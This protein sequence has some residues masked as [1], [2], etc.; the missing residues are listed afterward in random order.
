MQ[1]RHLSVFGQFRKLCDH[2]VSISYQTASIPHSSYFRL[3]I[4]SNHTRKLE[5]VAY[6][7]NAFWAWWKFPFALR[8]ESELPIDGANLVVRPEKGV[9]K[10]ACNECGS[11]YRQMAR[12]GDG[13]QRHD[14]N[15]CW[16]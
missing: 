9:D 5:Q 6:D 16:R 3:S 13:L 10:Q 14:G 8:Q 4:T 11:V 1:S 12:F 2:H 7:R 15:T